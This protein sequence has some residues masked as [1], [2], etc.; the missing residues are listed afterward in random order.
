M[1]EKRNYINK[2]VDNL[3]LKNLQITGHLPSGLITEKNLQYLK[4]YDVLIEKILRAGNVRNEFNLY[5]E[6]LLPTFKKKTELSTFKF[7]LRWFI[8]LSTLDNVIKI[9]QNNKV[10]KIL[11]A[12]CDNI[13]TIRASCSVINNI[14]KKAFHADIINKHKLQVYIRIEDAIEWKRQQDEKIEQKN[15]ST[16]IIYESDIK[17]LY[18]VLNQSKDRTDDILL[19]ILLSGCRVI[20]VLH[21]SK[22]FKFKYNQ[23]SFLQI[24]TAKNKEYKLPLKQQTQIK[25]PLLFNHNVNDFLE[26]IKE[27]RE[28]IYTR[29]RVKITNRFSKRLN[30]RLRKHFLDLKIDYEN[31][32]VVNHLLR[33][34]Y[35]N[36]CYFLYGKYTRRS[37]LNYYKLLL[38]HHGYKALVNYTTIKI[39]RKES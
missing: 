30:Q 9:F 21:T 13:N 18:E 15:I 10:Q 22:F 38:G 28:T 34:I 11:Y 26:K 35:V 3:I 12:I 39:L 37:P 23:N 2:D 20:E 31:K 36:Y 5:V 17:K 6:A 16:K 29:D 27:I 1:N 8:S 24:G 19:C 25:K 7:I 33:K 4:Y 14:V 32:K